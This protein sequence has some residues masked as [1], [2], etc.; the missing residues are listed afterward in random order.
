MS[1]NSLAADGVDPNLPRVL[2]GDPDG[3]LEEVGAEDVDNQQRDHGADGYD[4][5]VYV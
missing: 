5:E 2:L 3:L 1:F 4:D